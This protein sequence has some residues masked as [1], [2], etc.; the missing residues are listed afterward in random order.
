MSH[1]FFSL[2]TLKVLPIILLPAILALGL[3]LHFSVDVPFWNEWHLPG[4][5]YERII[6]GTITY[7]DFFT[8]N[9]ESIQAFPNLIFVAVGFTL[10]WH[11]TIFMVLSWFC[12][13]LTFFILLKMLPGNTTKGPFTFPCTALL[14]G[15][16][17]FSVSQL[18]SQL[19]GIQLI[20]FIPP[21]CPAI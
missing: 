6:E 18:E 5:L 7:H 14:L 17:L 9:N 13:L 12:I 8:Q 10:G 15:A 21:L 16:L 4:Y 1:S 3:T 2:Q 20:V 19:W 11:V